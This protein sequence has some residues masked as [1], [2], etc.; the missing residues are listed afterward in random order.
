MLKKPSPLKHKEEGHLLL[1]EKAHKE[2]H[3]GK[4]EP[5]KDKNFFDGSIINTS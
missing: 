1:N 3:G 4:L 2:A 5:E